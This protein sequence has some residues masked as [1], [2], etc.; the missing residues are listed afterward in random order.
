MSLFHFLRINLH[1]R[2]AIFRKKMY[3]LKWRS[4]DYYDFT[5]PQILTRKRNGKSWKG[6]I[7]SKGKSSILWTQQGE[8]R[9]AVPILQS[10]GQGR[11]GVLSRPHTQMG[12]DETFIP[13]WEEVFYQDDSRSNT[14][15]KAWGRH[16]GHCRR[17][18]VPIHSTTPSD[19]TPHIL[20]ALSHIIYLLLNLVKFAPRPNSCPL[21]LQKQKCWHKRNE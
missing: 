14:R 6:A 18:P 3:W 10:H 2:G 11:Q 21:N 9:N 15:D 13:T 8:R 19:R 20:P 12:R 5:S 4:L 16:N 7:G 1:I 17:G